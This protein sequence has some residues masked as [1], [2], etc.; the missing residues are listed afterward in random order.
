[1]TKKNL[2]PPLYLF[3]PISFCFPSFYSVLLVLC[4][5]LLG[6]KDESVNQTSASPPFH[7]FIFYSL[8]LPS[9]LHCF[10]PHGPDALSLQPLLLTIRFTL[11]FFIILLVSFLLPSFSMLSIYPSSFCFSL[12]PTATKKLH[13]YFLVS[14]LQLMQF[15]HLFFPLPLISFSPP[16]TD[17][18]DLL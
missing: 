12:C 9:F 8:A 16:Q 6:Q 18:V 15:Q 7:S 13:L 4:S 17:L 14:S 1:M 11:S 5:S 2:F 3:L 10:M